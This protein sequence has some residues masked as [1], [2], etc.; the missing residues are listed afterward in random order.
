MKL[1]WTQR[2]VADVEEISDYLLSVSPTSWERLVTRIEAVTE[3]LLQFPRM[4]KMGL[5]SGTREF[6]LS[7]TP[8]IIAFRVR[9][10]VVQVLSIRDGRMQLPPTTWE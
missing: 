8:Y 6:V 5:V 3:Y 10:D 1:R 4:G 2:A 7:G 9:E